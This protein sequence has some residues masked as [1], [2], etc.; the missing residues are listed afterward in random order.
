MLKI[1]S[2]M[3]KYLD[4][5]VNTELQAINCN[6]DIN[7]IENII[8]PAFI[9]WD[10]CVLLKQE[11]NV[12]LPNHFSPNQFITDRT[13]FEADYNHIHL[14]E[15]FDEVFQPSQIFK[16]AI[17]ILDVWT[18][19]LYRKFNTQRSFC[20][21]LSYDGEDIVIRFY[22]VRENESP[23]LDISSIESYLDGLMIVEI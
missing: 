3:Q 15:M 17:K 10:G 22:S 13:A 11:R 8:F 7:G 21:I 20:L 1:N 6:I 16:I 9:E 4:E 19:V 18:A 2:K 23:W 12:E 14:N 5:L